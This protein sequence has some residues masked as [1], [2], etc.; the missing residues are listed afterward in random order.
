MN[1]H[2]RKGRHGSN[3]SCRSGMRMPGQLILRGQPSASRQL[4]SQYQFDWYVFLSSMVTV[5]K[6]EV[7]SFSRSLGF[8]VDSKKIIRAGPMRISRA[9]SV[10]KTRQLFGKLTYEIR[11]LGR[12]LSNAKT[13]EFYLRMN[14]GGIS[15]GLPHFSWLLTDHPS[16]LGILPGYYRFLDFFSKS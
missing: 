3:S 14:V 10:A 8:V 13:R 7:D 5:L 6:K 16:D 2:A 1:E 11:G 9:R 4:L 15:K 12:R